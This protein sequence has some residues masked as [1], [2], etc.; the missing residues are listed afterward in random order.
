MKSKK[1]NKL[2]EPRICLDCGAIQDSTGLILHSKTCYPGEAKKWEDFY[3]EVQKQEG[4][5]K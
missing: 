2:L 3:E 4:E 1:E 5:K